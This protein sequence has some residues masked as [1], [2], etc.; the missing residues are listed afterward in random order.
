MINGSIDIKNIYKSKIYI[1]EGNPTNQKPI[2]LK[3]CFY[4]LDLFY[5]YNE[6]GFTFQYCNSEIL[7]YENELNNYIDNIE[8][9]Y[10]H[11]FS[12]NTIKIEKTNFEKLK[13]QKYFIIYNTFLDKTIQD[14]LKD[15]TFN[16]FFYSDKFYYP[17]SQN[18][19]LPKR[20]YETE[21][22]LLIKND[23]IL[24][25]YKI[26]SDYL[27]IS[28]LDKKIINI[29]IDFFNKIHFNIQNSL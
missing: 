8:N 7:Q 24:F 14:N 6:Y 2:F 16:R 3:G 18:T 9:L 1:K 17:E 10:N 26:N 29:F 23:S 5:F 21:Y 4:F 28:I 25:I 13:K 15:F 27:S 11:N 19:Y 22:L 20:F 12:L